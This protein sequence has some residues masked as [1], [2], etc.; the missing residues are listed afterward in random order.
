MFC[1]LDV[2]SNAEMPT[3]VENY[4]GMEE[5]LKEK[6]DD[7]YYDYINS[8]KFGD[9]KLK[10]HFLKLLKCKDS[11]KRECLWGNL[12]VELKNLK[13]VWN[14]SNPYYIG[15]GNPK[16]GILFLGK[17]KGFDIEKHPE[18][19]IKE[20]I[21]N[22]IQ[23]EYIQTNNNNLLANLGFNPLFPRE[24]HKQNISINHTWGTYAH[25]IAGLKDKIK[26][27]IFEETRDVNN[28]FFNDCFISEIN[29][30]P[31]KYSQGH[32]KY[33]QGRK[34][35]DERKV[36][37][38]HTF[39]QKFYIIIVGAKGYLSV[40]E[41]KDLFN[42]TSDFSPEEEKIEFGKNRRRKIEGLVFQSSKQTIIYCDQLSRAAGW[43]NDALNKLIS[44]IKRSS[45]S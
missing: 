45:C 12:R 23:W 42:I 14:L 40:E 33:S 15:F 27:D 2:G 41:L 29:H 31:S 35:I 4:T 44:T 18:L 13:D 26:K 24:Y 32:T 38:K 34:L 37:L 1:K 11:K 21:N 22:I 25:I 7:K 20:S 17:E 9:T 28:S 3:N 16:S 19:F 5:L 6:W 36:F 30:I 8:L 43:T 10:K 39:F